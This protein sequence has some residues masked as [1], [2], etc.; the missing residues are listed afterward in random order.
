MSLVAFKKN[1]ARLIL[2]TAFM[3]LKKHFCFHHMSLQP[4]LEI[5]GTRNCIHKLFLYIN[6]CNGN[7]LFYIKGV[8]IKWPLHHSNLFCISFLIVLQIEWRAA[9]CLMHPFHKCYIIGGMPNIILHSFLQSVTATQ[10]TWELVSLEWH[11]CHLFCVLK[12][13]MVTDRQKLSKYY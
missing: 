12:W 3:L 10:Q 4:W 6:I 1:L 7:K 13:C 2:Y 8:R 9:L 5:Y 11:Y